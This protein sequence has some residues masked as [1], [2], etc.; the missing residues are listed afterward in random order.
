M[1]SRIQLQSVTTSWAALTA[2]RCS[3]VSIRNKTGAAIKVSTEVVD[4]TARD[5]HHITLA[6]GEFVDLRVQASSAEVFIK[7]D[8]GASGVEYVVECI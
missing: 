5:N 1:K 7:A 8:A 4:D 2:H 3:S 6:D